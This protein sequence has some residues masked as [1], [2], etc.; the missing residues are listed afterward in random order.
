[1][2]SHDCS[3]L[4]LDRTPNFYLGLGQSEEDYIFPAFFVMIIS[5]SESNFLKNGLK[6]KEHVYL[7]HFPLSCWPEFGHDVLS[8][9]NHFRSCP[10]DGRAK[11]VTT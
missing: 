3:L 11:K 6:G 9:I 8:L 10:S 7:M 4:L 1:M 2:S 5:S